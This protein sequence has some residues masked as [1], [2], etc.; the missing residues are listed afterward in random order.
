MILNI[1]REKRPT[2]GK[3]FD[4]GKTNL[5]Y[6]G[7]VAPNKRIEDL[8][9]VFYFYKNYVDNNS[10]LLLVGGY[11][12]KEKYY[13]SVKGLVKR[14]N[15]SDVVFAGSVSDEKLNSCFDAAGYIPFPLPTRR[16]LRSAVGGDVTWLA[17]G[18][19]WR[20]GRSRGTLGDAGVIVNEMKPAKIAEMIGLL[21]ENDD[22]RNKI[23]EGQQRRLDH[24]DRDKAIDKFR[25]TLKIAFD[26]K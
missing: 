6:V 24:F 18:G 5:L 4:D 20:C 25:H 16:V 10:R 21:V 26:R 2:A 14:L 1:D 17:G 8:I 22:L 12:T 19:S 13:L 15:L 3:V 7:R 11:H 9:K 23:I